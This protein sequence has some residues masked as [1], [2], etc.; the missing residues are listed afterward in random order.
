M[1]KLVPSISSHGELR[2]LYISVKRSED[3]IGYLETLVGQAL[4]RM[5]KLKKF[6][7]VIFKNKLPSKGERIMKAIRTIAEMQSLRHLHIKYFEGNTEAIMKLL[8]ERLN[9]FCDIHLS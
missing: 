2:K 6:I 4:V 7:I 5:K 9:P 8:R 1:K 3:S